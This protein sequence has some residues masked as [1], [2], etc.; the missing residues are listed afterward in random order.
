MS[1][2]ETPRDGSRETVQYTVSNGIAT[3]LLDRPERKNALSVAANERLL[4]C[5]QQADQDDAVR[6]VVLTSADCGVFCSG[7]DLKE[8][9]M[10]AEQ[11]RDMLSV[12]KDPFF[13]RM[14]D[15]RK[16]IIA[17]MTG[18]FTAGGM[19]LAMSSD[20]RVGLAGTWGGIAEARRGRGSPWAVPL[21][22]MM[23]QAILMEMVVTAEP[24]PIERLYQLGF[25]NYVEPTP[26]AVRERASRLAETVVKNAPLSVIAGKQGLLK[27]V[28]LGGDAGTVA[29]KKLHEV[30]YASEDAREGPKAFAEKREPRW[31][32]R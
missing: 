10:L 27:G 17:A 9:A 4:E 28:A 18:H 5:W 20:I 8:T 2:S 32:G 25:V 14:R 12:L 13:E 15:V 16:P 23:P 6:V 21:L 19:V 3:I 24:V 26:Q 7:M 29:S 31:L 22:W 11:G 30:V 1:R